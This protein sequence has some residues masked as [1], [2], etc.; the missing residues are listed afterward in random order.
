MIFP[1]NGGMAPNKRIGHLIRI[2]SEVQEYT[3]DI[4]IDK[5]YPPV[6]ITLINVAVL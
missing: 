4:K 5:P 6:G 1:V 3:K 2:A